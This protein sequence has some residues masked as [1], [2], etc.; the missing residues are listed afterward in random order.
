M[1]NVVRFLLM[2]AAIF[3]FLQASTVAASQRFVDNG[4]GTLTDTERHLIWQKGD[5]GDEVTFAQ[6]V[7]SCADLRLGGYADWRL[8]LPEEQDMAV[9]FGLMMPLHT[10]DV[11][12]RFDL[13][14]TMNPEVLI[15]FNYRPSHGAEVLRGYPAKQN[16]RAFVR[17]VRSLEGTK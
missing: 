5:N 10:R 15:P 11:H 8:P 17:C 13:Y 2:F 4:D 14:W 6:A 12:A 3:C 9:A 16:D 7:G 1:Q